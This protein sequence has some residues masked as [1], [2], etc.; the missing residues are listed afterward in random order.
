MFTEAL[1]GVH[2]SPTTTTK[3]APKVVKVAASVA[4]SSS[5]ESSSTGTTK[6]S[7]KTPPDHQPVRTTKASRLRAAALGLCTYLDC[8]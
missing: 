3:N 1:G 2:V 8:F 6:K 5:G 4:I 7:I